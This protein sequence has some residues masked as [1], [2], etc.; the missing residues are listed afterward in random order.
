MHMIT[1]LR[2]YLGCSQAALAKEAGITQP[3]LSEIE[4]LEPY[5]RIDKYVRLSRH[6][7]IGVDALIQNDCTQIPLS[8][9]DSHPTPDYLPAPRDSVLLLGRQGEEFILRRERER[10]QE[11]FPALAR[12]VLPF[13]KMKGPSPGYDIL[14]FD[15][16][17]KPVFLEVKTS[18]GHNGNFR[19][20]NHE[21]DAAQKLTAA[22]ERYI[23]CC[24]S[25]WGSAEQAMTEIPFSDLSQT[26]R[27]VPSFYFCKPH[28]QKRNRPVSGL[29]YHRQKRGL[30][31][32]DLAEALGILQCDL[33]LYETEQRR[34]S[35]PMYRKFSEC[36]DV[37][38]DDL[39]RTY[40]APP[41]QE[42]AHG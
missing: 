13:Y 2:A 12:L 41:E 39:L 8:F 11:H 4:T 34:P 3:D 32:T 42:A 7:G 30:R 5:G 9:F 37:P 26:H 35:V 28:P 16:E 17:G 18:T 36:L 15:D 19:F 10:L 6:L 21:L 14:S 23:L 38:I 1:I 22:G 31:Q 40:P 20:T 33:S 29:A 24:I 27:I 25:D